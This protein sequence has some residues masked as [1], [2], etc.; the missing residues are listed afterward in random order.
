MRMRISAMQ[1]RKREEP[2]GKSI[3][4]AEKASEAYANFY[5]AMA[6]KRRANG[7]VHTQ[8]EESKRSVCDFLQCN[9]EERKIRWESAY[10]ASP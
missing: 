8:R 7:K 1:R 5:N 6:K 10:E 3:R 9:A 4:N 2:E